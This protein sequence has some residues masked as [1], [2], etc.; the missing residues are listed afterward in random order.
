MPANGDISIIFRLDADISATEDGELRRLLRACFPYETAL[1]TRRYVRQAPAYRWLVRNPS[2]E[3]IAHL[4]A[5]D[6]IITVAGQ[7]IR[8]AGIAEV[9]VA[10]T[11]RGRGLVHRMLATAHAFLGAQCIPFAMLFGHPHVYTSSG[12]TVIANTI[13]C[14]TPILQHVN[15]FKGRP[16][17]HRLGAEPWPQGPIDLRGPTF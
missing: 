3:L 8:I 14:T 6:K 17:V 4:A 1:I 5:H 12:Y 7:K 13:H 16:M 11:H 10:S 15:P 2:G 9:C